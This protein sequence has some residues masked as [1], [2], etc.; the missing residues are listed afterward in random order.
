MLFVKWLGDERGSVGTAYDE[1]RALERSN[2]RRREVGRRATRSTL[3][4]A[5]GE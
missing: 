1:Q 2:H 3:M 5:R 4:S